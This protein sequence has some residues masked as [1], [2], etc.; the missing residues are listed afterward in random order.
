CISCGI[1]RGAREL[2]HTP[3]VGDLR[4][5]VL[6]S[7]GQANTGLFDRGELAQLAVDTAA[8]GVSISTVGV[9]LDFDE[10]TMANLAQVGRGNYYFVENTDTLATMFDRELGGLAETFAADVRLSVADDDRVS[11][12][13]AYGYP[14]TREG[15]QVIVP[16]A[17]LRAGETR[18]VVLRVMV[19]PVRATPP[20][21]GN[22][23]GAFVMSEVRLDWRRVADSQHRKAETTAMAELVLDPAAVAMSV[24]PMATVAVEQA[25]TAR[26]LEQATAIYEKEGA[27]AAQRVIDQRRRSTQT[28]RSPPRRR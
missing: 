23:A 11:I 4:R 17:D 25:I 24:D 13:E 8:H 9:G 16:I 6:I 2:A 15:N 12:A 3:L 19:D 5:M 22:L 1:E 18:K 28:R 20:F 14:M 27:A 26:A 21:V 7:D 10:V